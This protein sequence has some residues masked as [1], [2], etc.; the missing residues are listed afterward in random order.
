MSLIFSHYTINVA[1]RSPRNSFGGSP[2]YTHFCTIDLPHHLP[3]SETTQRFEELCDIF[4]AWDIEFN[5]TL[6]HVTCEG[7]TYQTHTTKP[8]L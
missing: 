2:R 7:R 6:T 4:D 5:L 8:I 1:K 3:E